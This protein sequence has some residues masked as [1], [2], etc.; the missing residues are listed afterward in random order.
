MVKT[1][2]SDPVSLIFCM[3]ANMLYSIPSSID[4]CSASSR[5]SLCICMAYT[6]SNV[7]WM[8]SRTSEGNN[9]DLA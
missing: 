2:F 5:S 4:L 9:S 6:T 3:P 7:N 8:K 1:R